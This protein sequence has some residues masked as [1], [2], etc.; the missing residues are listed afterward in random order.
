MPPLLP[1]QRLVRTAIWA[2]I[3]LLIAASLVIF[4]A[5]MMTV[6]KFKERKDRL[7]ESTHESTIWACFQL[8]REIST[9]CLVANEFTRGQAG[10]DPEQLR[11]SFNI[12]LGELPRVLKAIEQDILKDE[13]RVEVINLYNQINVRLTQLDNQ[14]SPLLD[15][16]PIPIEMIEQLRPSLLEVRQTCHQLAIQLN[17]ANSELQKSERD[18]ILGHYGSFRSYLLLLASTLLAVVL[19]LLRQLWMTNRAQMQLA[20][21]TAEAQSSATQAA[22]ANKAKSVF[23]ATMSHEIRTPLNGIIGTVELLDTTNLGRNQL[24]QLET[25]RE[26][27]SSLLDVINDVLD[28]SRMESGPLELENRSFDLATMIET[29]ID[30]VSVR[31][32]TRK[33]GLMA[34]YPAATLTG[35]EARIRQI[36]VNLCAN[37]VKFT[38]KGDVALVVRETNEGEGQR[39]L[40]FEVM[41]TGIGIPEEHRS[42]LFQEFSQVEASINRRFGGSGLG[43]AICQRLVKS[44]GGQIGVKSQLGAGSTFWFTLPLAGEIA[45]VALP[46]PWPDTMVAVATT[47]E[48]AWE[49]MKE[50]WQNGEA[51]LSRLTPETPPTGLR[52]IDT[53]ATAATTISNHWSGRSLYFGFNATEYAPVARWVIEGPLTT[54]RLRQTLE[55]RPQQPSVK[56]PVDSSISVRHGRVL[57]AEDNLINQRVTRG[58]LEKLGLKVDVVENGEMALERASRECFD[59]ILMD[60]Q[61]PIM[62]GLEASRRIRSLPDSKATIPIIA[63]TAN[64]FTTDSESCRLV[65]MNDFLSKPVSRKKLEAILDEWLPAA[66]PAETQNPMPDVPTQTDFF[67]PPNEGSVS[68]RLERREPERKATSGQSKGFQL[69]HPAQFEREPSFGLWHD[70][71]AS[72]RAL[73]S[74]S[75]AGDGVGTAKVLRHIQEIA[76]SGGLERVAH[77]AEETRVQFETEGKLVLRSL[78]QSMDEVRKQLFA[79]DSKR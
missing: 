48:L 5:G 76:A 25:I 20:Q 38:E 15:E 73:E 19:L 26:C 18:T 63:L 32:R 50:M 8:D 12:V 34:A 24:T 30:I 4:I 21:I 7:A 14:F 64:A 67:F 43:L 68:V 54:G 9:F 23:L 53:R 27:G 58:L 39:F 37:A 52:L 46:I 1:I 13:K 3:G 77:G 22:A 17:F 51:G 74:P 66:N 11:D 70:L 45:I 60:M 69:N 49:V 2:A 28:F 79:N 42:R 47:T 41:D 75:A 65:G 16:K 40:R 71:E 31:A 61:M 59:L 35:D 10:T 78:H 55:D 57:V 62:D 29:V 36:L 56:K 72:A 33:V 6:L 44:M